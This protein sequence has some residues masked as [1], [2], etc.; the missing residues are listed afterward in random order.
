MRFWQILI[1]TLVTYGL[2][3]MGVFLAVS[4]LTMEFQIL[5]VEITLGFGA[6]IIF[7]G[8]LFLWGREHRTSGKEIPKSKYIIKP[9]SLKSSNLGLLN[10]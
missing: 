8:F 7:E 4:G 9:L 10:K 3:V 2:I 6:L 1:P 5:A